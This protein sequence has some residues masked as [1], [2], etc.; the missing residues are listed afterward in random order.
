MT[1][2]DDMEHVV[3]LPFTTES[4]VDEARD[5]AAVS[6]FTQLCISVNGKEDCNFKQVS[7]SAAANYVRDK[8]AAEQASEDNIK[9]ASECVAGKQSLLSAVQPNL[10]AGVEEAI[11]PELYKRGIVRVCST[12]NPGA[13]VNEKTGESMNWYDRFNISPYK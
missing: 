1:I 13:Q 9:T 5:F 4:Q 11:Q 6:G 2:P 12:N 7:T 3:Y 8:Y 10:Q